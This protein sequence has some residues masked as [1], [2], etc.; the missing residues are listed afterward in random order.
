MPVKTNFFLVLT[1]VSSLKEARHISE[2][3]LKKKLAAC[4]SISSPI[5]SHFHWEGK[6]KKQKEWQLIIK[7]K[8]SAYSRLEELIKKN[9]SYEIP[10]VVSLPIEKALPAYLKWM[11]SEIKA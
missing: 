2:I 6:I 8:S 4:V 3:I 11:D 7:A 5:E 9:H 1:T 10:E